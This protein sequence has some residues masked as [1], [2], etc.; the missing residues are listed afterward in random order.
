LEELSAKLGLNRSVVFCGRRSDIPSVMGAL[1]ILVLS[2]IYEGLPIVLL[3][4]MAASRPVVSTSVGGIVGLVADGETGLLVPPSNPQALADACIRI[5]AD[6]KLRTRMGKAG[7]KRVL[8]RNSLD[9]MNMKVI[10]LYTS[11]LLQHGMV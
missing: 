8:E 2:S 6:P 10:N 11:L 4:G 3:E 9:E 1:D 5:I 7:Y